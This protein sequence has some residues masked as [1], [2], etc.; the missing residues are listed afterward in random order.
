MNAFL[1][2]GADVLIHTVPFKLVPNLWRKFNLDI[3]DLNW[4]EIKYLKNDTE[5]HDDITNVSNK[6]G[7]I[8]LF[9]IRCPILTNHSEYLVY[10]GRCKSTKYQNLRKRLREYNIEKILLSRPKIKRM[11]TYWGEHLIVKYVE[12]TD[13]LRIDEV[14]DELF[15]A[16]LPP[17]NSQITRVD[18]SK[19]VKAFQ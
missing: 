8:Y 7:G 12:L 6:A 10:V 2:T 5:V 4:T 11:R 17:F 3:S 1:D 15:N 16:I 19:G 9:Y 14:E 13:N 18:T